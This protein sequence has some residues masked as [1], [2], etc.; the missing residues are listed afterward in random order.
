MEN[1][2]GVALYLHDFD[3]LFERCFPWKEISVF[4]PLALSVCVVFSWS[5]LE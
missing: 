4:F 3:D 5:C 2:D 1:D